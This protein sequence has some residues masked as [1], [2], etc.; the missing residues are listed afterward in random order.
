[1]GESEVVRGLSDEKRA[2]LE[3][4]HPRIRWVVGWGD[5]WEVAIVPPSKT[6][7]VKLYKHKLHTPEERAD[8]QEILWRKMVIYVWDK[9]N[10]GASRTGETNWEGESSLTKFL[11]TFP[12]APEGCSTEFSALIGIKT[13]ELAK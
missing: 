9:Y 10:G 11:E 4:K 1:M 7:D 5:E 6:A 13:Q 3:A 12:M 8:A 2:E